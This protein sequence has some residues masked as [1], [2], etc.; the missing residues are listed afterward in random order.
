[1]FLCIYCFRQ[2]LN[3]LC[4]DHG[5]TPDLNQFLPPKT[6][7]VAWLGSAIHQAANDG[8]LGVTM[9]NFFAQAAVTVVVGWLFTGVSNLGVCLPGFFTQPRPWPSIFIW[10]ALAVAPDAPQLFSNFTL[11]ESVNVL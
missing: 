2:S 7:K 9:S 4:L 11:C 6:K 1:M 10:R 5:N 3:T 8:K